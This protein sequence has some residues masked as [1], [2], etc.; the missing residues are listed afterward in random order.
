MPPSMFTKTIAPKT[1]VAADL[2]GAP[3]PTKTLSKK[4]PAS[5]SGA[6]TGGRNGFPPP[7]SLAR[8]TPGRPRSTSRRRTYDGRAHPAAAASP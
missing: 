4:P 1:P 7:A 2:G 8:P 5:P 6:R 3:A